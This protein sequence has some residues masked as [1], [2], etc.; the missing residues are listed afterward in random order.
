MWFHVL[1]EGVQAGACLVVHA[2]CRQND[3]FRSVLRAQSQITSE[4]IQQPLDERDV[5]DYSIPSRNPQ[6]IAL[7]LYTCV[8]L[9]D[10]K[11]I[12]VV[13]RAQTTNGRQ[14]KTKS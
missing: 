4:Y 7:L 10:I 14:T 8:R 1:C 2:G 11:S 12:A 3:I 5:S 13:L 6:N 9:E